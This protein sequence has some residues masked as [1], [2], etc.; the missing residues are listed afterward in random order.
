MAAFALSHLNPLKILILAVVESFLWH[1][2][3]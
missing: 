3:C 2:N 1:K